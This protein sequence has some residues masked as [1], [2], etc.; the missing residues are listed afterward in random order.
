MTGNR[1]KLHQIYIHT[2]EAQEM[3]K[4]LSFDIHPDVG[5]EIVTGSDHPRAIDGKE[6]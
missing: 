1:D 2:C 6:G 4:C 5:E 3:T